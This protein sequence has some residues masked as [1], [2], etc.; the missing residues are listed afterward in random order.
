M[1]IA[2]VLRRRGQRT[3]R[4]GHS[5]REPMDLFLSLSIA[6]CAQQPGGYNATRGFW[7]R[8]LITYASCN[9]H[10]LLY[11]TWHW[12]YSRTGCIGMGMCCVKMMIE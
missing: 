3:V 9:G 4:Y 10:C 12:Y 8:R 6:V 2:W 5:V 11:M 7:E 1:G